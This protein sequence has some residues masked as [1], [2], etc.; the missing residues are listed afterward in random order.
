MAT[1]K[2]KFP[3]DSVSGTIQGNDR[4]IGRNKGYAATVRKVNAGVSGDKNNQPKTQI[5]S[6]KAPTRG[7][8]ANR[9]SRADHYCSCD[10]F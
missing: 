3:L 10:K 4:T 5:V 8:S 9:H 1:S 2:V 6:L 7:G